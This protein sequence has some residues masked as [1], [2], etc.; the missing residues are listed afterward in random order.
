MRK[1]SGS[2]P[3]RPSR[4]RTP[5]EILGQAPGL[6]VRDVPAHDAAIGTDDVLV[7]R[8]RRD[9]S[10]ENGLVLFVVCDNLRKG[11]A[12][13]ALQIAELAVGERVAELACSGW[14]SGRTARA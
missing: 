7:G 3:S 11:A 5:S 12:L 14:S 6:L 2:R 4:L 1:R 13:N 10:T 8:I 9:A